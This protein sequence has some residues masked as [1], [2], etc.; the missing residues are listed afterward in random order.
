MTCGFF[1]YHLKAGSVNTE[2]VVVLSGSV[3]PQECCWNNSFVQQLFH[4]YMAHHSGTLWC[5]STSDM[6]VM[7]R[8]P[9][10]CSFLHT[11]RWSCVCTV[12]VLPQGWEGAGQQGAGRAQSDSVQWEQEGFPGGHPQ[13]ES[14]AGLEQGWAAVSPGEGPVFVPHENW[15]LLSALCIVSWCPQSTTG[16]IPKRRRVGRVQKDF[17]SVPPW[18]ETATWGTEIITRAQE[19]VHPPTLLPLP[20]YWSL[21]LP[22]LKPDFPMRKDILV[23]R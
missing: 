16:P 11:Q 5:L 15:V 7:L 3:V 2:P 10:I 18:A 4:L 23:L 20:G 13:G 12:P 17:S 1:L 8:F 19:L 14:C 21:D 6:T 22:L 9:M